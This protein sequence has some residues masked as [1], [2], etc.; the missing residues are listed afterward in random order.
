[1]NGIMVFHFFLHSQPK[2][3]KYCSGGFHGSD[4]VFKNMQVRGGEK[5]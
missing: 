4:N 5:I 2:E 3:I 1:M